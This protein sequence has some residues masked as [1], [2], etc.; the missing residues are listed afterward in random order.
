MKAYCVLT[1]GKQPEPDLQQVTKGVRG[2]QAR[3][4]EASISTCTSNRFSSFLCVQ[5]LKGR[6][7]VS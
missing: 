6:L 2:S 3:S 4:T 7:Y 5:T 1:Q